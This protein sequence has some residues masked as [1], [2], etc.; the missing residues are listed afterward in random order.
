MTNEAVGVYTQLA[1]AV[2]DGRIGDAAA[3]LAPGY[4][5]EDCRLGLRNRNER[6]EVIAQYEVV[7]QLGARPLR[8]TVIETRGDRLALLRCVYGSTAWEA[9]VLMVFGSEGGLATFAVLF[10]G[11]DVG[12]ATEELDRRSSAPG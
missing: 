7:A 1:D 5:D 3:L 2:A 11:N 8:S 10:D 12:R 9:E 4:V 6:A